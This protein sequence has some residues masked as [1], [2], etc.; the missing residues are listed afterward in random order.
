[1]TSKIWLQVPLAGFQERREDQNMATSLA[2]GSHVL[3]S[4]NDTPGLWFLSQS[5]LSLI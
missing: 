1:M 2:I 5:A 4:C 3:E